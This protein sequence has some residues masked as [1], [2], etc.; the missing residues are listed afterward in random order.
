MASENTGMIARGLGGSEKPSNYPRNKAATSAWKR[1]TWLLGERLGK[2]CLVNL[3][4]LLPLLPLLCTVYYRGVFLS[5]TA[6]LYPFGSGIGVGYPATPDLAGMAEN[7]ILTTDLVFFAIFILCSVVAAVGLSGGLYIIRDMVWTEGY[8][9]PSDFWK[10]IRS[11]FVS[12]LFACLF[13]SVL[14]F[15][16]RYVVNISDYMIAIGSGSVVWLT[17]AKVVAYIALAFAAMVSLWMLAI[18]SS[19]KQNPF[20]LFKNALVMM[21]GTLPQSLFFGVIATLPFFLCFISGILAYLGVI[22]AIL[23]SF[24]FALLVWMC[25]AQWAFDKFIGDPVVVAA[26]SA[27]AKKEEEEDDEEKR[28]RAMLAAGKSQLASRPMEGIDDGLSLYALPQQFTREDLKRLYETKT[29]IYTKA[30]AYAEQH[31]YD[32]AY[33]AYNK[34]WDE[35]DKILQPKKDKKGRIKKQPKP[36]LLNEQ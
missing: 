30:D 33:A 28:L 4:M 22:C 6:V 21:A 20:A 11:N 3:M 35:R 27:T 2:L 19:Y 18:G 13:F 25:F 1:C 29:E 10:G 16:V 15:V 17:I 24:S 9:M 34:L 5:K 8:Y 23:I 12:T 32:E 26:P 31:K 7:L 14:L 36:K